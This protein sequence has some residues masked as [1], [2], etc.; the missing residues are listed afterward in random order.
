M[1]KPVFASF[2]GTLNRSLAFST[3]KYVS[4]AAHVRFRSIGS[5]VDPTRVTVSYGSTTQSATTHAPT[6]LDFPVDAAPHVMLDW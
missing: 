6:S 1:E 5:V 2:P 3:E 4:I